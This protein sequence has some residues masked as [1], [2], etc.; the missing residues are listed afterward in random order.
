MR[1]AITGGTGFVGR[2]LT[3]HLLERGHEVVVL[4]RGENA[5]KSEFE[6][7]EK[8]TFVKASLSQGPEMVRG[9]KGCEAI[10]NLAGINRERGDQTYAAVHME[11]TRN[12]VSVA[13][14]ANIDRLIHVS[15][16]RARPKTDSPY[17]VSKWQSEGT[18]E[19]S[20]FKYTIFKPGV[21]Y[22]EGDQFLTNLKM[23]L[24]KIP[25]FALI[26]FNEQPIAPV[27]ID[28]FARIL[29]ACLEREDT[30][31]KTYAVVGPETFTL[32]ELVDRVGKSIGVSAPQKVPVPLVFHRL[33]A[34][35]MEFVMPTP[36]LTNAQVTMLN[37]NLAEPALPCNE[38]PVEFRPQTPFLGQKKI[39]KVERDI[40]AIAQKRGVELDESDIEV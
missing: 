10:Y 17:H 38:L 2:H 13:R 36:L 4:A 9:V 33:A 28:D 39:E 35:I 27:F 7:N 11:G 40:Q 29:A 24:K 3:R 32:S 26:G 15:F 18:I 16:L 34:S 12:L 25:V 23:M 5:G 8:V 21:L 20:G 1:V 30:F 22:G 19:S 31:E 37:E 14:Q 6:G